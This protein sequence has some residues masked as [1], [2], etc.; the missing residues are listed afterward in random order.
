M[1]FP[2]TILSK[3]SASPSMIIINKSK[4]PYTV[5][6]LWSSLDKSEEAQALDY[7]NN[8]YKM[9]IPSIIQS[10]K[11][12]PLLK[13]VGKVKNADIHQIIK[14]LG[15]TTAEQMDYLMS[16]IFLFNLKPRMKFSYKPEDVKDLF[17]TIESTVEEK[18]ETIDVKYNGIILPYM[19]FNTFSDILQTNTTGEVIYYTRQ[20]I[21]SL[22]HI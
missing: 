6:K 1:A 8:V 12:V 16:S 2:F 15:V 14:E 10:D 5:I 22:I 7:E 20:V 17:S 21:L 9:V 4:K 19:V 13:A 11:D 18:R 3:K